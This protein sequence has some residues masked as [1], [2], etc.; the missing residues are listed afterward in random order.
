M[1]KTK[2][3]T[4]FFS[5]SP[6]DIGIQARINIFEALKDSGSASLAELND[7]TGLEA[8]QIS[9][10]VN[11]CVQKDLLTAEGSADSKVVK[12]NPEGIKLLG[13]GFTGSECYL[14]GMDLGGNILEK[15]S[16]DLDTLHHIKGKNK[17]FKSVV[18]EI[19]AKSAFT[20][21]AYKYVAVAVPVNLM[22][23]NPKSADLLGAGI[24][25]IFGCDSFI[26]SEATAAAY[27]E[28][29]H[30]KEAKEDQILYLH[31]DVGTG[32]IIKNGMIFE[33]KDSSSGG[34]EEYLRPWN[35]F[36]IVN[37]AIS[38]VNKGVGT[39]M[40]NMVG[41][42]VDAITLEVI[43]KAA[44]EKDELAEDLIKRSGLA[45]GVRLAYLVN[46]FDVNVTILGGG[47]EMKN[48]A[49]AEHVMESANKFLM[50][51]AVEELRL[52][53]SSLGKEAASI[54]AACLLRR[55]IFTDVL[56]V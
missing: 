32:V 26:V 37:T 52:V 5:I 24:S 50:K 21:G 25:D 56:E 22:D 42:D 29:D 44:G 20:R 6:K 13:V 31:S 7:R 54:G 43:F 53:S 14:A 4:R 36:N 40:V 2:H 3:I 10:Y 16:F 28:K 30:N 45:L 46:M 18:E 27:G 19:R 15:E 1:G 17:E 12:F 11:Y 8:D 51:N 35:Q 38:L 34:E 55:E 33:A 39:D 47:I 49:F 41:G 9:E 23:L 48:S